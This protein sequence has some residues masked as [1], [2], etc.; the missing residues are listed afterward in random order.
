MWRKGGCVYE[1]GAKFFTFVGFLGSESQRGKKVSS[2]CS[3]GIRILV[4]LIYIHTLK[5]INY[6]TI[7]L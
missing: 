2:V 5:K 6:I 7:N 1:I 3:K 4:K